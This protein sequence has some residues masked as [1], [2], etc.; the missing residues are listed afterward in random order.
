MLR[1][2]VCD[3]I[4]ETV[5]EINDYILE[6]QNKSGQKIAVNNF[7]NAEDLWE[8]LKTDHCD[9][10]FL[11]IELDKMNGVE[12]GN[13]IRKELKDHNIKIVVI[14]ATEGYYKQLFDIQPLNFLP[15]PIDK[16]KLFEAIDLAV[17][18]TDEQN[19][20]FYLR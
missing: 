2:A 8:F 9:L 19:H 10:I 5:A 16:T 18:L 11:D 7:Y 15:K 12:L 4:R 3:D 1:I 6:Y 14:S 17:R 20:I 13:R